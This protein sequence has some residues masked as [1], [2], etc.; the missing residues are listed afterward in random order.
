MSDIGVLGERSKKKEIIHQKLA[1]GPVA[2]AGRR[3]GAFPAKTLGV[4]KYALSENPSCNTDPPGPEEIVR[5]I[6][7]PNKSFVLPE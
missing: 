7:D 3:L 5:G 2:S 6:V 1:N 4:L